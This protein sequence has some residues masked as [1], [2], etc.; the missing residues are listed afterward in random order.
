MATIRV[1]RM[2]VEVDGAGEAVLAIHGLGGGSNVWTPVMPALARFKVVRPDLPGSARSGLPEGPLSIARYVQAVL[3]AC[4]AAGVERAHVLGHSMG[5]IVA[6][7]LAVEAPRLVRSLALFG[8]LLAPP[9]A[10]RAGMRARAEKARQGEAAMQEIAD[11]LVGAALSGETRARSPVAVA[12]VREMVMR[13]PP[14][15]YARSCEALAGAEAVEPE[16]IACPA[17]LVTGEEDA[18]APAQSV[19]DIARRLPA[20]RAEV[21][22]RCGHWTMFE[23]PEACADLLRRHL[24]QRF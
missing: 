6:F 22:A 7:H 5:T 2:A 21:L 11:Q 18:I 17:L 10:A 8:P 4:A 15:G 3:R 9:E 12:A 13:Q 19:R 14:E 23:K 24:D 20:G 1:E 16:A